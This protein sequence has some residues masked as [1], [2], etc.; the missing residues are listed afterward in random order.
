MDIDKIIKEIMAEKPE[1]HSPFAYGEWY[2]GW[3]D[4][5]KYVVSVLEK[6][7]EKQN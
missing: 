1:E 2:D 4:A 6:E 3:G 7:K 5:I